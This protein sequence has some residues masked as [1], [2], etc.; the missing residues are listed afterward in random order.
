MREVD[1]IN[2]N[3]DMELQAALNEITTALSAQKE[4]V[5]TD[6][7]A[8]LAEAEVNN[9]ALKDTTDS[10]VARLDAHKECNQKGQVYDPDEKECTQM[11]F[12]ASD[13]MSIV[14]HRM[15]NGDD[16]RDSG[17]LDNRHITFTKT[18]DDTYIRI[19]YHD[20]FRVHGHGSWAR[21]NIMICDANGNG[22]DYCKT[23]ERLMYWR[24]A[25][26]QGQWW[27]NDHWSGS[28]T[29]ICKA[30][31]NRDIRKG[32]YQLRVYLDHDRYDI[33]TGHNQQNS[34]MVDEV[35]K[36]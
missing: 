5:D 7:M 20:N 29:G 12:S 4:Y 25:Y 19:F 10:L 3:L 15:V 31:G 2:D 8:Q 23:P 24:Y 34:F 13:T 21:W 14:N 9:A 27:M 33:Y 30:A 26:H 6:L 28:V 35:F 18:Q 22:C 1:I 32:N 16:G 36:Y 17:Y 11:K